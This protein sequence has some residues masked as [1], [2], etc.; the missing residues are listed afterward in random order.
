[1][2]NARDEVLRRYGL[3]R[4]HFTSILP[5]KSDTDGLWR[6][7]FS[8]TGYPEVYMFPETA[9]KLV[10]EL[11]RLGEDELRSRIQV[12]IQAAKRFRA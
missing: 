1:M 5:H 6:V 3:A 9:D 7:T 12:A 10:E 2:E 11:R 4:P 8:S